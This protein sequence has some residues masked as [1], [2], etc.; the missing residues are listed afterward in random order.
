MPVVF[1]AL[2]SSLS[3]FSFF[4]IQ[5]TVTSLPRLRNSEWEEGRAVIS[6]H[7]TTDRVKG[8]WPRPL[9]HAI[10]TYLFHTVAGSRVA[11]VK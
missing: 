4:F 7:D 5:I 10:L 8:R 9:R 3:F 2:L 6:E 1:T 11:A